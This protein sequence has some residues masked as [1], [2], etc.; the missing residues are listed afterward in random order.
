MCRFIPIALSAGAA[1]CVSN[2]ASLGSPTLVVTVFGE[3]LD[4]TFNC[5]AES[6][7]CC[8]KLFTA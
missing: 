3:V 5:D 2:A 4:V 8:Y 1:G 6:F 7:Q